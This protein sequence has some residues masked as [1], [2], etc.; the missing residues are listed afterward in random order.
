MLL[1]VIVGLLAVACVLLVIVIGGI[2]SLE[3][4]VKSQRIDATR[5][6]AEIQKVVDSRQQVVA[7]AIRDAIR[8]SRTIH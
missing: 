5:L 2:H 1:G 6:N 3:Q 8:L 4:A 7:T